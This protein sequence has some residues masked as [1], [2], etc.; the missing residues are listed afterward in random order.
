MGNGN[1]SSGLCGLKELFAS[2]FDFI[3][4]GRIFSHFLPGL[5]VAISI[6]LLCFHLAD[7]VA[8]NN[9]QLPAGKVSIIEI[10]QQQLTAI[11]ALIAKETRL[12][13]VT[14]R[15]PSALAPL[16]SALAQLYQNR[17]ELQVEI[18]ALDKPARSAFAKDADKLKEHAVWLIILALLCGII[19]SQTGYQIIRLFYDEEEVLGCPDPP[20]SKNAGEQSPASPA[21]DSLE[22]GLRTFPVLKYLFRVRTK[23]GRLR[24]KIKVPGRPTPEIVKFIY[25]MPY[26]KN[27]T[28]PASANGNPPAEATDY[29]DYLIR[30]YYRFVEFNINTALALLISAPFLY[31]YA[32]ASGIAGTIPHFNLIATAALAALI[33]LLCGGAKNA[34]RE[35]SDAQVCLLEGSFNLEALLHPDLPQ[36]GLDQAYADKGKVEMP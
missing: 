34:Y 3:N 27:L 19:I 8:R 33:L 36:P 31:V 20:N 1:S 26:L 16:N 5:I 11:E 4:A 9:P 30:E 35:W 22:R 32:Q 14:A 18:N 10:K 29:Y 15:D 12:M 17:Q 13:T 28:R 21:C 2:F 24:H 25:Y 7:Y 6:F 23:Y